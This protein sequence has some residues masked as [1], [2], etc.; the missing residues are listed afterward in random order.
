MP[1]GLAQPSKIVHGKLATSSGAEQLGKIV[2]IAVGPRENTNPWNT[3]GSRTRPFTLNDRTTQAEHRQD[4]E[5][6]FR[7]LERQKRARLVG[8]TFRQGDDV[9]YIDV[10]YVDLVRQNKEFSTISVGSLTGGSL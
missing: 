4:I 5:R 7:M 6:H 1:T 9:L 10:E 2:M 3:A 8:I